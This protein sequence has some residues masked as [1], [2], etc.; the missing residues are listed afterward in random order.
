MTR[1][2]AFT[3]VQQTMLIL[4]TG[5]LLSLGVSIPAAHAQQLVMEIDIDEAIFNQGAVEVTGTVTCSEP[6]Q[7]TD[8]FVAVRQPIGRFRSIAGGTFESLGPCIDQLPFSVLV[9][10]D[11]GQFKR[12]TAFVFAETGACTE[13]TC[14]ND[15][16]SRVVTLKR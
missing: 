8:I 6:T 5:L 9:A 13:V 14:D 15:L 16:T 4:A 11:S 12:G 3:M 10:P 2:T 1:Q 7:F